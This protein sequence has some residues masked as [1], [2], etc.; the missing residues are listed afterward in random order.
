MAAL[1]AVPAAF[2]DDNA[3]TVDFHGYMRAGVGHFNKGGGQIRWKSDYVGRLG[4]ENDTYGELE[5]GSRV[6]KKGD[7]EFYIDSM[8][9]VKSM[10]DNDYEATDRANDYFTNAKIDD[11][12]HP[13]NSYSAEDS[14]FALRQL[15]VQAKGII[16]GNKDATLWAGK[17]F[18]Q[19]HDIHI[20]DY[21][22]WDVSGSGAGLENLQLGPGK[23]SL[24]WVRKAHDQV[25]KMEDGYTGASHYATECSGK[26]GSKQCV[27]VE[28]PD[29]YGNFNIYDIRYA[30]S[31]WDGGY[32]EFGVT[33]MD[34]DKSGA[35]EYKDGMAGFSTMYTAEATFSGSWGFNKTTIQYA[36]HGW[37]LGSHNT[38]YG[39]YTD[40]THNWFWRIINQGEVTVF[41][42]KFHLM[43][44]IRYDYQHYG[45]DRNWGTG[46]N[47]KTFAAA[48]RPSY[49]ITT[50]SRIMAEVG[51]YWTKHDGASNDNGQKYTLAYAIAPSASLWARPEIRLYVSY[52]HH[53]GK[54]DGNSLQNNLYDNQYF[55]SGVNF[56]VQAEAWW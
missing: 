8:V 14:E 16:P 51:A 50:Y 4:N 43:H 13:I 41:S 48:I 25:T 29:D 33:A 38:W 49:Q 32:L 42:D 39:S 52:L 17:R 28:K 3:P 12:G 30:G 40:Q 20:W 34:P 54:A 2:A 5:L 37:N 44:A 21:Y 27:F 11:S 53:S 45:L 6:F 56:G 23:L 18:F 46:E 19:R 55:D 24:T 22:Y 47:E 15:N 10:G 9:A 36:N 7:T 26:D 1:I 31:Y 35:Q